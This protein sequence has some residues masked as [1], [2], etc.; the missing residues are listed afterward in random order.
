VN[1][2]S[3][4]ND[5]RVPY[6]Y[7]AIVRRHHGAAAGKGIIENEVT[8]RDVIQNKAVLFQKLD[9]LTRLNGG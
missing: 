2:A 4:S 1:P 8:A 9:D 7:V 3:R 6:R 5:I